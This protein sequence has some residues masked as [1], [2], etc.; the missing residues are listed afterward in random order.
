MAG[1][2]VVSDYETEIEPQRMAL[3]AAADSRSVVAAD[4]ERQPGDGFA[5]GGGSGQKVAVSAAK[6]PQFRVSGTGSTITKS[7]NVEPVPQPRKTKKSGTGSTK[8]NNSKDNDLTPPTIPGHRWKNL[9]YGFELWERTPSVSET[10]KRSSKAKYL[11][12]YTKEA[13]RKLRDE[14]KTKTD[15]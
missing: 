5:G 12:Y 13:V 9:G 1:E 4:A 3:P 6:V 8:N 14:A 11:T 7:V 2:P 15:H 10:G